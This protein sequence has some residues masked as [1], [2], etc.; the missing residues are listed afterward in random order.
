MVDRQ[1]PRR[2]SASL[3]KYDDNVKGPTPM[4]HRNKHGDQDLQGNPNGVGKPSTEN[5]LGNSKTGW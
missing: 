1:P 3:P 4:Q 2:P 5:K